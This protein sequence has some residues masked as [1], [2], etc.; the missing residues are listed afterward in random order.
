M[1]LDGQAEGAARA[2]S[3]RAPGLMNVGSFGFMFPD[4]PRGLYPLSWS[5]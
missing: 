3:V 1:D 5:P 4:S 2:P